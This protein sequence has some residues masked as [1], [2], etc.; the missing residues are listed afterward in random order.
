MVSSEILAPRRDTGPPRRG[1]TEPTL[2]GDVTG[3]PTA[4]P[5]TRTANLTRPAR[6]MVAT[7]T[8]PI[9]SRLPTPFSSR[10]ISALSIISP[11]CCGGSMQQCGE[12]KL[13]AQFCKTLDRRGE[14]PE[15]LL[16][17]LTPFRARRN[18]LSLET[19]QVSNTTIKRGIRQPEARRVA[20]W[21]ARSTLRCA[22]IADSMPSPRLCLHRDELDIIETR[23]YLSGG[24]DI[25]VNAVNAFR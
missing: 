13:V 16:G 14:S 12:S 1:S 4:A 6:R 22:G 7:T 10:P 2:H 23:T 5:A 9:R 18:R 11:R 17:C 15:D 8:S 3:R 25:R 21:V 20:G 19:E 24:G